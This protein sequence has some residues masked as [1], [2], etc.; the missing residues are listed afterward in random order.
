MVTALWIIAVLIGFL[1]SAYVN[2]SGRAWAASIAGALLVSWAVHA[3]PLA[4]NVLLTAVSS[5]SPSRWRFR[6]CAAS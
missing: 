1:A 6:R 5:C 4:L 2:V 3:L